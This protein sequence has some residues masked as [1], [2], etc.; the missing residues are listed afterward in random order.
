MALVSVG[1]DLAKNVFAIH[2]MD[3]SGKPAMVW[4]VVPLACASHCACA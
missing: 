2:G 3:E 4:P 1:I